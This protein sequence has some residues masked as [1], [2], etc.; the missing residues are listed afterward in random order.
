[1]DTITDTATH[2]V[3]GVELPDDGTRY[4]LLTV[5]WEYETTR[6]LL[7]IKGAVTYRNWE[8][9]VR[10]FVQ[11]DEGMQVLAVHTVA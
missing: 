3:L 6:Y 7:P 10:Q 2:T 9:L 8:D 4:A 5:R 1:M 11:R